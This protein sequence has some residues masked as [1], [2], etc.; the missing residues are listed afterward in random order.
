[1][2]CPI[3]SH[4]LLS[5]P[6]LY[7]HLRSWSWVIPLY[8]SMLWSRVYTVYSIHRVQHSP[9]TAYSEYSIDR[10]Q[11]H[12]NIDCLPLPASLSS[13][14]KACCTQFCTFSQWQVNQ[15]IE[16]QLPLCLPPKLPP[17]DWA[18]PSTPLIPDRSWPTNASPKSRSGNLGVHLQVHLITAS[19]CISTS[20]PLPPP[21]A[22]PNLLNHSIPVHLQTRSI[23]A[24]ENIT[25]FT[26]SRCGQQ[27]E[28]EGRQPIIVIPLHRAWHPKGILKEGQFRLK[29]HRKRVRAY[30]GVPGHA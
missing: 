20:P 2:I 9:S 22:S 24:S 17:P 12:P 13:L 5:H 18:P 3:S 26:R 16:S 15:W 11:H 1:M 29:E 10:V 25:T 23:M 30:E 6:Q 7:H 27:V 8:I 21:G 14:G 19:K 4:L 28:L